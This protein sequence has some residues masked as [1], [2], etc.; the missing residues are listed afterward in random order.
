VVATVLVAPTA[1]ACFLV[2][3]TGV[4]PANTLDPA[5]SGGKTYDGHGGLI[6]M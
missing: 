2:G 5:L 4:L 1:A 3:D 6:T